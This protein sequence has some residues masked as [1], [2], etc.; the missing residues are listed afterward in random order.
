M[1]VLQKKK[2]HYSLLQIIQYMVNFFWVCYAV[3]KAALVFSLKLD[4][5]HKLLCPWVDNACDEGVAQFPPMPAAVLVDNY[6]KRYA[7]LMQLLALPVISSSAIDCIRSPQLDHFLNESS[8]LEVTNKSANASTT[9]YL[10]QEC[11][12]I[13]SIFYYQVQKFP[14][15]WRYSVMVAV[16]HSFCLG[17]EKF[18]V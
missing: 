7:A 18:V 17:V 5:G 10:G 15:S 4:N 2:H 9:D 1:F 12:D 6:K 14:F 16:V 3:E 11:Q 13:S 8:S